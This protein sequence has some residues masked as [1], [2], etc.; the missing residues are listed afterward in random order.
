MESAAQP[1]KVASD[2]EKTE[3]AQGPSPAD[4]GVTAPRQRRFDAW[5]WLVGAF[6]VVVC[7]LPIARAG[8]WDPQEIEIA[9][10]ARRAAVHLWGADA[11]RLDGASDE[12]P[13]VEDVG[14]GEL[15]V[16]SVAL[17][18][19]L[20][21]ASAWAARLPLALWTLLGAWALY[22][23][24]RRLEGKRAALLSAVVL[25]TSPVVFAQARTAL[26]DAVTLSATTIAFGCLLLAWAD[27]HTRTA[28]R[29]GYVCA[30]LLGVAAGTWSRGV[31]LGAALPLLSVGLTWTI[32]GP[33]ASPS[34]GSR[35]RNVVGSCCLVLGVGTGIW[36]LVALHGGD[37]DGFS[38]VV[39]SRILDPKQLPT[40]DVVIH[41]LGHSLFPWSALLPLALGAVLRPAS[42]VRRRLRLGL[43]LVVAVGIL[44]YSLT[45]ART[46]PLPFGPSFALAAMCAIAA[47][48]FERG[49]RGTF[50][51][52]T[53]AALLV[54]LYK[55]FENFPDKGFSVFALS[56]TESFPETLE[57][58]SKRYF[59]AVTAL[60]VLAC[61]ALV[62]SRTPWQDFVQRWGQ[63]SSRVLRG[64]S[65]ALNA[66]VTA[67]G[68]LSRPFAKA[69]P[70]P[71]AVVL[72]AGL[73][74]GGTLLGLGYYPALAAQL[75]PAGVYTAY[76]ELAAE[77]EPLAVMGESA[78]KG[79]MFYA[80]STVRSFKSVEAAVDWLNLG[81]APRKWLILK[82]PDLG[83]ANA[84]FR[85]KRPKQ[86]LPILN[87]DSSEILLASNRLAAGE[88]NENPLAALLPE[89]PPQLNHTPVGRW[90]EELELLGWEIREAKTGKVTDTLRTGV[91]YQFVTGYR[92]VKKVL[93]SWES[94]IHIDGNNKR[95]NG[96]HQLL[97][98]KYP[99][100]LWAPG[101]TVIDTHE[102][103]LDATYDSGE[104]TVYF[105]LF[106]GSKR[107]KLTAGDHKDDRLNAGVVRVAR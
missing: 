40:H 107:Y 90:G 67:W 86:N 99:P 38:R 32:V 100:R 36:G 4:L 97:G 34:A 85:E 60:G 98:G 39:G 10:L 18:L 63:A 48:S 16:L 15:P 37:V 70:M 27:E 94:F 31:L 65:R 30:G 33:I 80:G 62:L 1:A 61:V 96:D 26:G 58:V 87:G 76:R 35:A 68:K 3:G 51:A 57:A 78:V 72:I 92:V 105:G 46:G 55:D 73:G 88:V 93:S 64:F 25:V 14:R 19:R 45:I 81:D 9:D 66:V 106:S 102:F 75:S 41:A 8:L 44:F 101:D 17:G 56:G 28:K 89:T 103:K 69:I 77:G 82:A 29:V 24:V 11:L 95:V 13:S 23:T 5:P 42:L 2:T 91:P 74:G 49:E 21:G 53:C 79:S 6:A 104:Y 43:V 7:A 84:H 50:A 83:R 22:W 52:M 47:L 59:Q 20:F 54:L 71:R 12:I